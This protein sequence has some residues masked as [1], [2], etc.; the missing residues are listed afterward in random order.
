MP[1]CKHTAAAA[2]VHRSHTLHRLPVGVLS[3]LCVCAHYFRR[4]QLTICYVNCAKQQAQDMPVL[5]HFISAEHI[6]NPA[7]NDKSVAYTRR[8]CVVGKIRT[9]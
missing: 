7:S 4:Y 6:R 1:S 9:R 8:N 2:A 3:S 5:L